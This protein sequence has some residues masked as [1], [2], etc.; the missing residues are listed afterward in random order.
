MFYGVLGEAPY[1]KPV[2]FLHLSQSTLELVS[3]AIHERELQQRL[4]PRNLMC[5]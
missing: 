1:S 2:V 5:A 4:E 3:E